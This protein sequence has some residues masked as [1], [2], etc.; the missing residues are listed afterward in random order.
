MAETA[1]CF[2]EIFVQLKTS[3]NILE[4]FVNGIKPQMSVTVVHQSSPT[5]LSL[6]L[7]FKC[8]NSAAT[9]TTPTTT[10][11][12]TTIINLFTRS[13]IVITKNNDTYR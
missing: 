1:V 12:T 8:I 11:N 9:T 7:G 10:T 2:V 6:F 4:G 5:D 3:I 13:D